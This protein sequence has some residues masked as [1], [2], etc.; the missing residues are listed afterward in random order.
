MATGQKKALLIVGGILAALLVLYAVLGFV[1]EWQARGFDMMGP[2]M[3]GGFGT[4]F[5]FPILGIALLALLIWV[6]IGGS[7][8]RSGETVSSNHQA[9]SPITIL[10]R[11]YARGDIDKEEYEEKLKDLL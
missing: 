7:L 2:G 3:M 4:M 5:L 1:W 6:I 10:K 9:D 11:R 8:P